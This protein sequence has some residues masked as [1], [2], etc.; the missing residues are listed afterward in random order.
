M[1]SIATLGPEGSSSWQAA[2]RFDP[3]AEI[4][5]Y[6][7][8]PSVIRAFTE[9][10]TEL[11]LIPVYNTREGESI[12]YFRVMEKIRSAHWVNNVVLPIHLSLGALDD[13]HDLSMLIGKSN[14][15]RQCEEYIT[16]NYPL[17]PQLTVS[18]LQQAINDVK[19][20]QRTDHGFIAN[21][22][23]LLTNGLVVR[24]REVAPHNQTRF[25]VISA[26]ASEP[27]GYD[28]T[29]LLTLPLNDRVGLLV[30]I[31]SEFSRRGINM[32]DMRTESDVK[33]QKLQI[34]LEAEG[35]IKD[36]VLANAVKAISEQIIQEP[37]VFQVLG[38]FPRVDM[39][40]KHISTFGFIG[41]G[42]MSKW[43]AH[44]L[45]NEGYKS[46]LTG[47]TSAVQPEEMIPRVDVVVICVPI[48]ATAAAIEKY[49]PLLRDGQALIIMAG[50]AENALDVAIAKTRPGV[51]IMLVHNLWGPQTKTMK[52]KN[53]TVVRT[54]RS[55][56]L[57]SEFEAFLYK[58]GALINQDSPSQHDLLMGVGQ[59]LPTT[60]SVALAMT[61]RENKIP[62]DEIGTHSTLTSLYGILA[63]ARV[64]TQNPRT[65]AEIMAT[66][67]DGR[68]I[69]KS[70][71]ENLVKLMDMANE[72]KIDELC[73]IIDENRQY[74]TDDFLNARMNQSLAVDETL[75]KIIR[76]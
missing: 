43:F 75:G 27:T 65:Y 47:R 22:E 76:K 52:N 64:H 54:K 59:K 40:T 9:K 48:S 42:D 20:K 15:F 19:E 61:L 57:C 36:A 16:N 44:R 32:I 33:T 6:P 10:Q 18:D 70:F 45:E 46:V 58:H 28:A 7:N 56:L 35:H 69:V 72:G 53:A 8:T 21:E 34:Y 74:L 63:M 62:Q 11:A 55:G 50:V 17:L 12:E 68:K 26:T 37:G 3:E 14:N 31:L 29:A 51:E 41:T 30:D 2:K 13:V 23:F 38:S 39:R 1:K 71:V 73:T 4:K 25:A 24:E 49:G 5:L 66:T 60:V 67:G